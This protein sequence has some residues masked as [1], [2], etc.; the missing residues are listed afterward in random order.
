[1]RPEE[2]VKTKLLKTVPFV[3]LLRKLGVPLACLFGDWVLQAVLASKH[4]HLS[5][6]EFLVLE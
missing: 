5:V 4:T 1:M 3:L 6:W 2:N